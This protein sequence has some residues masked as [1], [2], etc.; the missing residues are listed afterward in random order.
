MFGAF[1]GFGALDGGGGVVWSDILDA[2]GVSEGVFGL[3]S[4][5]GLVVAFPI[6]VFGGRL[7]DHFDKR[8]LLAVAGVLIAGAAFGFTASGGAVALFLLLVARGIGTSLLDLANNALAMDFE[9]DSGRHIMGPLHAGYSA[10]GLLGALAVW[11]I[12]AAGGGHRAVYGMIAAGFLVFAGAALWE[13]RHAGPR[14]RLH[15]SDVSPHLALRLL[16]D[17]LLRNL[18]IICAFCI[19]GEVLV[20]QWASIYLRDERD[21]S[22]TV[23]VVAL[24]FYGAAM[25]CGRVVNGPVTHRLGPRRALLMQGLSTLL[26]GTLIAAGGPPAL[27]VLGA[28]LVGLGLA[29]QVPTALSVAGAAHPQTPGAATGAILMVG[30]TGLASA[31]FAAGLIATVAST[32]VVMAGIAVVGILVAMVASRLPSGRAVED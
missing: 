5:L 18:A 29:G 19:F 32:R 1:L 16:R 21:F 8:S 23:A 27:A 26:G 9:R 20:L 24:A 11:L 13:R 7:A 2:F 25:F 30:Y 3:A 6:L 17:R 10:G 15:A 28:G 22:A 14:S 31:P 4:G 12:F